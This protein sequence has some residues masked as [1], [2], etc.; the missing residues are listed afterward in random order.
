MNN[1]QNKNQENF[2]DNLPKPFFALAPMADVTDPAFRRIIAKC[3]RHGEVGGGPD[4]FWT[5]FV[6][7]DG[8]ASPGRE[9]LKR[10]LEYTEGEC[11]I[12]AQLFSSHPTQMR[13]AARL[14]AE[15]G[16]DGIDINMGCPDKS[17]EKQGAGAAMIKTPEIAKEIIEAAKQG[18]K[19]AGKNIPLSVKTRVGYNSIQIKEWIPFLLSQDIATLTIHAR[20]RKELSKVP[21]RWEHVKEIVAIRDSMGVKTKIIGNGDV[22]DIAHG[23]I[24]AE[25]SGCD[26]VMIG[27]AL[28][29]NPWIFD[30]NRV[31][32]KRPKKMNI[33]LAHVL[34]RKWMKKLQGS[35]RYTLSEVS[36]KEKLETMLEHTKLFMEL[37]GD[38]KSFSIMKKHYKAYVNGFPGAKELR[39]RLMESNSVEEIEGIVNEFLK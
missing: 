28:F 21:A 34:P 31:I 6:S 7:A 24:L 4:V 13:E 39:V 17:I 23:R 32:I 12:V 15:L 2:W 9:I 27:R 38:I 10:D 16:F 8:L 35:D 5:E 3:S 19:D 18:I 22:M 30:S 37:L 36:T 20:T 29:G 11:P 25:E 26:G 33:I 1:F 14:C